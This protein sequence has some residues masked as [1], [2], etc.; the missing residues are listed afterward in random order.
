MQSGM[1][2]YTG[3][4]QTQLP[5]EVQFMILGLIA[6]DKSSLAACALVCRAWCP[7]ARTHHFKSLCLPSET[8]VSARL[9][10]TNSTSSVLPFIRELS[11]RGS[12]ASA[13]ASWVADLLPYMRLNE[14]ANLDILTLELL[15]WIDHEPHTRATLLSLLPRVKELRLLSIYTS[16]VLDTL[17]LLT[18]APSLQRLIHADHTPTSGN[19][20]TRWTPHEH[21]FLQHTYH[22]TSSIW[23]RTKPSSWM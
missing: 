15:H 20:T 22:R 23:R 3:P 1:P 6:D 17:Q 12:H 8:N 19:A 10:L 2:V 21:A 9:L 11:I 16:T 18:A 13:D 4:T 5:L 7:V 14:L